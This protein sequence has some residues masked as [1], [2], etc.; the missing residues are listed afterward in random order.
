M[1]NQI[2]LPIKDSPGAHLKLISNFHFHQ[3]GWDR[4]TSK[5]LTW[6]PLQGWC[7]HPP[8]IH[9]SSCQ[10]FKFESFQTMNIH[11][12]VINWNVCFEQLNESPCARL[13]SIWSMEDVEKMFSHSTILWFSCS[14]FWWSRAVT[15][16]NLCRAP[17]VLLNARYLCVFHL[18][19]GLFNLFNIAG[20]QQAIANSLNAFPQIDCLDS[21]CLLH[22]ITPSD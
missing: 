7:E 4:A 14:S 8:K 19:G 2:G 20:R 12:T 17:A 6:F 10:I 9:S 1:D 5:R 18:E 3:L 22:F 16:C 11:L 15:A 21:L 13:F